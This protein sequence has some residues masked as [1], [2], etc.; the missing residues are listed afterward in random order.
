MWAFVAKKEAHCDRSDPREDQKGD[1]WDHVALTQRPAGLGSR[2]GARTIE[3]TEL[4]VANAR[5]RTGSRLMERRV[6]LG[7]PAILGSTGGNRWNHPGGE[8]PRNRL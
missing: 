5:R 8:G 4:L 6:R 1:D 7:C 2:T 3:N